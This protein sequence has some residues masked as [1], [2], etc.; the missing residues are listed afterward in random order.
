METAFTTED[1]LALRYVHDAEW[2]DDATAVGYLCFDGGDTDLVVRRVGTIDE[3]DLGFP[4]D[5]P[6]AETVCG[7]VSE[8]AWRPGEPN[9]LAIV[10]DGS[11]ER[12]D[13][14]TGD[15]RLVAAAPDDHSSLAWHPDGGRLAAIRDDECWCF[16]IEAGSSRPLWDSSET[17]ANGVGSGEADSGAEP[18]SVASLFGATPL[19]WSPDG[20]LLATMVDAPAYGLGLSVFDGESGDH[21]WSRRPE[22]TEGRIVGAF[23]W[24][25]ADELIYAEETVDGT[26]RRYQAATVDGSAVDPG[27]TIL[28]ERDDRGLARDPIVGTD[29]G[30]FAVLSGRSGYHHVYAVDVETRRRYLEDG[31]FEGSDGGAEGADV[32]AERSEDGAE[33]LDTGADRS[34]PTDPGFEGP[35]V[36]QVTDGEFEARGDALDA[37]AWDPEGRRLAFATNE[38]DPGDRDVVVITVDPTAGTVDERTVLEDHPGNALY[39]TWSPDGDRL[40]VVRAGRTTPADVHVLEADTGYLRRLSRSHP[41]PDVFESFPDPQP[42]SIP[43]A[44][45]ENGVDEENSADGTVPGYLYV[46]PD[47]DAGDDRPAVVWCHGGPIRQMRR[48]FHHMRSYAFFHAFNHLLVSRG[49]LVLAINYRGGIGYGVDFECAITESIGEVD[50]SDCLAAADYLRDH[51]AVGDRVGLWGLSYGGYLACAV[52][53]ESDA[54]DCAVNFAGVWDWADWVRYASERHW[55]AG[56]GFVAR[57]GGHPDD[58]SVGDALASRYRRASPSTRVEDL[59]TPLYSLHGTAD[60]NVPIDQL[61]SLV[62]AAVGAG[63]DF[64]VMYY[65]DENH[66]FEGRDTWRDALGRV[67]AFLD[68]HLDDR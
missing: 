6:A 35:G 58:V 33:H 53:T 50:V 65:P 41:D 30:R 17:S 3:T 67:L 2:N 16:D 39:P 54:Y 18:P 28:S 4:D 51:D 42:V 32:G 13:T 63:K 47:A 14:A 36:V 26:H 62:S 66:M 64:E 9:E 59:D 40:A 31:E 38:R 48:G 49:Y 20:R 43:V 22:P 60:P 1:A 24:V 61:D 10:A 23:D 44:D 11:I 55:G 45:G 19:E 25:G 52:A 21:V 68:V 37:P 57:F 34:N 12:F 8:Y 15:R 27:R 46:P 5:E 56:R 29:D 7:S